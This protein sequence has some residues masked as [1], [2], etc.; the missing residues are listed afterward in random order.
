M[1]I[2]VSQLRETLIYT[3]QSPLVNILDDLE[4]IKEIDVVAESK[5]KEYLE[6]ALFYFVGL[7][8]ALFL[9]AILISQNTKTL[10]LSLFIALLV[11]IDIALIIGLSYALVERGK[12]KR[13]N[14]KNYRYDL[15]KQLL[16][17][18]FRDM[19]AA[20]IFDLKLSFRPL[21]SQENKIGTIPHPYKPGWKID[22]YRDE[23]LGIQ[24]QFVDKTRFYLSLTELFKKQYGWKRG[25]SG[26]Q[27]YKTKSSH[28]GLDINLKLA[29]PQR[30]Y[31]AVKLL[32]NEVNNAVQLHPSSTLRLIKI[33]DK[34]I[35][36]NVRV[37][38]QFD[39]DKNI[40]YATI[41]SMFLSCYQVLNL[42]KRLSKQSV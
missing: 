36:I 3:I 7:V 24:G 12:F 9:T 37:P 1:P 40:L 41:T 25:S 18:L 20:S 27:K 31:G 2:E 34:A 35:H 21:E 6:K 23:W 17:M 32:Q 39:E 5:Q 28:L 26:K 10:I 15:T 42:A 4:Q 30:R 19:D 22:N 16:Q 14:F 33:T 29:Y 8:S 11:I 38:R 13:L